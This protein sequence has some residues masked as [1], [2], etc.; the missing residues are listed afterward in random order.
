VY[1]A[2]YKQR[3]KAGDFVMM[4]NSAYEFKEAWNPELLVELAERCGA[5]AVV[6][7]DYPFQKAQVT[8]EAAEKHIP[9]F[10]Q[11]RLLTFFVPQSEKGDLQ[12][13]IRAYEW[14][15]NH[16]DID[17]IGMSILGIPNALPAVDPS[18]ARV[19][20][21]QLLVDR[22]VFNSKKFHHFLGLNGGPGLEIPSLLRMGV[23]NTADSSGPVWHAILGHEYSE[24]S[25]SLQAVRKCNMPVQ[26]DY[27]LTRDAE[28]VRRIEC[29]I[30]LTQKLF[31][32]YDKAS[33]WFAQESS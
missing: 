3:S 8:I 21:A 22:G 5:H 27:P 9:L 20:M 31:I 23:L 13:W 19:V 10:K 29:N 18:F 14:A 32:T 4:D 2:F 24:N 7:P 16:P 15:A 17:I 1:A 11:A 12:D 25:D 30:E 6:L 33:T 26:F 28:T